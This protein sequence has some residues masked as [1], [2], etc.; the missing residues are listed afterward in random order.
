[1]K[2]NI[3]IKTKQKIIRISSQGIVLVIVTYLGLYIGLYLDKLT[4]MTPNFMIA[5]IILGVVIGFSGF[6]NIFS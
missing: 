3:D 2:N 5:F 1:M 6:L 4:M